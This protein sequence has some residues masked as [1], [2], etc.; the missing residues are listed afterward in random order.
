MN[1]P[2]FWQY[3]AVG[4]VVILAVLID[5]VRACSSGSRCKHMP[6]PMSKPEPMLKVVNAYK[7]FGGLVAVDNV[8]IEVYPVRLS[9]WSATTVRASPR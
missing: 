3:V 6:E 2:P 7:R 5:Q 8:S 1:V 9:P 4:C